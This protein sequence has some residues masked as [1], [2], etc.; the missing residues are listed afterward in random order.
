[1]IEL[2]HITKTFNRNTTIETKALNDI[3]MQILSGQFVVIVGPNGSGK[4]TLLNAIAGSIPVDSGKMTVDGSEITR[5]KDFQRSG[6]MARIFQNPLL[7]TAPELSII[8]NFRLAALRTSPKK[9]IVGTNEKFR[10]RVREKISMLN[11]GLENKPDQLMGTLSGGQRQALTLLMAVMDETKILLMD[12]PA[13]ALD[14]KTS[15]LLMKLAEKIVL[16]FHLTTLLVTHQMKD[17]LAF[18]NRLILMKEGQIFKDIGADKK[19]KLQ[20]NEL[21]S[22]FDV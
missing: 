22:W 17:A 1:M 3:N 16:E 20:L 15:D 14:P 8:E 7:G 4:T 19:S 21:Y 13:A 11:L 12:E 9:M 2:T 6:W 18:G 10:N 5:L